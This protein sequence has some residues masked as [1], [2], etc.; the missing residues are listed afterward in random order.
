[1]RL[2]IVVVASRTIGWKKAAFSPNGN[3][4]RICSSR[5]STPQKLLFAEA[6]PLLNFR[7]T[8]AM[9]VSAPPSPTSPPPVSN[10]SPS[11]VPPVFG[12]INP[13]KLQTR[14]CCW[15]CV[16]L[17]GTRRHPCPRCRFE[18]ADCLALIAYAGQL[19]CSLV[20]CT[21]GFLFRSD[22]FSRAAQL[23]PYGVRYI[24]RH[25]SIRPPPRSI[26]VGPCIHL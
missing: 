22:V 4:S 26:Y 17:Q 2:A 25:T 11:S 13:P 10:D 12:N 8:A 3:G 18:A 14:S 24:A 7:P 15:L 19:S 1:M 23:R 20:G 21:S 9:R 16:P 6:S 5:W